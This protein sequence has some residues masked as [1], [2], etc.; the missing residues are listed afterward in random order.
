MHLHI[1]GAGKEASTN[2][3]TIFTGDPYIGRYVD[4]HADTITA[5]KNLICAAPDLLAACKTLVQLIDVEDHDVETL[6]IKV[7]D[8]VPPVRVALAAIAK[9]EGG[10]G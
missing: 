10:V 4:A 6:R 2:I 3:A 1:H 5:N 8:L 9:A 7:R